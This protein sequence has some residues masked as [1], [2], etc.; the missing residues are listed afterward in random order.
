MQFFSGT[1][2]YRTIFFQINHHASLQEVHPQTQSW[3]HF[4]LLK[5]DVI[6]VDSAIIIYRTGVNSQI[7]LSFH[8]TGWQFI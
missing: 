2:I 4:D 6:T 3:N 7:V 1:Q 8:D 5:H